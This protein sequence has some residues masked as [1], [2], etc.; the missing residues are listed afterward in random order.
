MIPLR[1]ISYKL[2]LFFLRIKKSLILPLCLNWPLEYTLPLL[3]KST[4]KF[5]SLNSKSWLSKYIKSKFSAIKLKLLW[6]FKILK[7]LSKLIFKSAASFICPFIFFNFLKSISISSDKTSLKSKKEVISPF[8][9]TT[10]FK[11]LLSF[12]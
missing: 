5:I 2:S 4:D 3:S 11:F 1:S 9:L 12:I 6:S 8:R 7:F 10:P